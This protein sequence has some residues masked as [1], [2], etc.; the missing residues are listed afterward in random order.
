MK[1]VR[2]YGPG[3]VRIDDIKVPEPGEKE[4]LVKIEAC[5]VCGSDLKAYNSGNPRLQPP[6]VM[7]H[8]FVGQVVKVGEDVAGLD[9]NE[10]IV[11]A[12]SVGCGDCHYCNKGWTNLC[13]N[14]APMGFHFNGGMA[15]YMI[16]PSQAIVNGH[17]VKVP[18]GLNPDIAALAEPLSCAVNCIEK[19]GIKEGE[20]VL[21]MGA[22]PMGILNACVARHA[23]AGRIIMTE[24]NGTRLEQAGRFNIDLLVDPAG[25]DLQSLLHKETG[26][27]GVDVVIV[28]APSAAPQEEALRLVRKNGTVC[29][30]ASLPEGK[31]MLNID[32]RIIHYN[33]IRLT[34]SSDSTAAHVNTALEILGD[35]AFP[36]AKIATHILPIEGI[37]DAFSLMTSGEALRVVLKP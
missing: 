14:L 7:G 11:M 1:A 24:V 2:Y 32:S 37:H 25:T 3:D 36:A 31:S 18:A 33:E 19:C 4:A 30:F 9:N 27:K 28:T 13:V 22:G 23:G 6:I 34:G 5:A 21:V 17:V 10:R 26:G 35:P 12:T 29:L 15:E 8:E 16:V 20:T